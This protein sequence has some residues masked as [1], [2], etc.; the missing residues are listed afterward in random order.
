MIKLFKNLKSYWKNIVGVLT[1]TMIGVL[2]EL[3][4]PRLMGNI[5]DNGVVNGDIN[6]IL[7]TGLQMI[8][9]AIVGTSSMIVSAYLSSKTATGFGR[10]L[11]RMVFTKVEGYSLNEMEKLGTSSLIT[12]TTNDINQIQQVAIMSLRMMVRAPLML[13]GGFVMAFSTNS[14]LSR[15]LLISGPLL[16]IVIAT[17]GRVAFPFFK[18]IQEKIDKI[19]KVMREE[20]SGIRVIRA[21]NK[22]DFEKKRFEKANKDLTETFLKVTRIMTL[23][24]PLI[25]IILNFTNVAVIWFGSNLISTNNMEVGQLMAFIQ[26]VM[27][28]MFSL[29]MVSVI[30]IMIPRASASATRINEVLELQSDIVDGVE[31]LPE[32]KEGDI[33]ELKDVT[34][35][36]FDSETPAVKD[37]SFK[38]KKGQTTA[39]IGGTGS[40]KSTILNLIMRFFEPTSGEILLNGKNIKNISQDELRKH[41]SLIPQKT[42]L[43]TGTIRDNIKM[44]KEDATDEEIIEALKIAQAYDFV[45]KNKEGL[46]YIL[47]QGGKNLSGGQKQRLSIA[48]AIV[49]RPDFYLFDDSFSALDFKTD[50]ILREELKKVTQNSGVLIVAQRISTIMDAETIVVLDDG[51]IVGMGNHKELL[52]SC[53]VYREIAQSQL[54]EEALKDE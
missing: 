18:K 1:F 47:S 14:T 30:F 4:L 13:I 42:V 45:Q 21:F 31:K 20:L 35:N 46:D 29:I 28:I 17:I 7:K 51:E 3:F 43:F 24:M 6:Y 32:N 22:V 10:D 15:V 27:Q 39:I 34:F 19:N 16:L 44:G 23:V 40:G 54:G 38:V 11:R 8:I 5:V 25:M 36:Y 41:F 26:Y 53:E 50:K 48:R 52:K 9:F 2:C 33:L 49:R 12:R 37:I